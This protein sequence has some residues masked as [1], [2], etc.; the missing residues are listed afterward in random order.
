MTSDTAVR[1]AQPLYP[2]GPR[3]GPGY[4]VP[5]HHCLIGPMRPAHGHVATSP[6]GEL[7]AT[8]LLCWLHA[9]LGRPR[10][11]PSFRIPFLLDLSPSYVPGESIDC[12]HPGFIDGVRLRPPLPRTRHSQ[13]IHF[14][15]LHVDPIFGASW[16]TH[17]VQPVELLASLADRTS[18]TVGL[19]R[20][21]LPSFRSSRSPFSPSGITTVAS[22]Y[23]HRQDF[24]LLERLLASLHERLKG[25]GEPLDGLGQVE[26]KVN[27][28]LMSRSPR[29]CP[30]CYPSKR[31]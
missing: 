18:L 14:N 19:Q 27:R 26:R 28:A 24:H 25:A 10:V 15:P 1:A 31:L 3:S 16:F 2:R 29:S 7:Y 8:P 17:L 13:L 9:S 20:L 12:L 4:V 6:H 5:V 22:G 21:L 30:C 11:V 23:F